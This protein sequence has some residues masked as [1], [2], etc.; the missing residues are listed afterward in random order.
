[1]RPVGEPVDVE[2]QVFGL[3]QRGEA[4]GFLRDRISLRVGAGEHI[5]AALLA[6]GVG[7]EQ[8]SGLFERLAISRDGKTEAQY[9][10]ESFSPHAEELRATRA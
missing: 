6:T 1:M 5:A 4:L 3:E 10:I 2:Q 7:C 8:H 9:G